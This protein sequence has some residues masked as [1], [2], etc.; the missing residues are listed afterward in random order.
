MCI[1]IALLCNILKNRIKERR[2]DL[3][4]LEKLYGIGNA[5]SGNISKF[6]Q[7]IIIILEIEMFS[8]KKF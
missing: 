7:I 1:N 5:H 6:L 8:F 3:T 2:K 4:Q